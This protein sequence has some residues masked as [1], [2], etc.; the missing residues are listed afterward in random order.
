MK[1]EYFESE[2]FMVP[3]PHEIVEDAC[4]ADAA[5]SF[6][7]TQ[8]RYISASVADI[9]CAEAAVWLSAIE[10]L[11]SMRKFLSNARASTALDFAI[12]EFEATLSQ[13]PD[14]ASRAARDWVECRR[15]IRALN[16]SELAKKC[17]I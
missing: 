11:K 2:H 6:F 17:G 1:V 16:L 8:P 14:F 3:E 4:F 7:W 9:T 12:S 5:R 10:D 13:Y 15:P